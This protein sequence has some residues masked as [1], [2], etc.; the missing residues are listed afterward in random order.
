[1][2]LVHRLFPRPV[3]ASAPPRWM[4]VFY[5][6]KGSVVGRPFDTKNVSNQRMRA[7][8][9]VSSKAITEMSVSLMDQVFMVSATLMLKYSFTSQKPP[10]LT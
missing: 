8:P 2:I 1:M 5:S 7:K 10:S 9:K 6:R 3:N 4:R